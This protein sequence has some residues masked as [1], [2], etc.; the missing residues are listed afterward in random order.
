MGFIRLFQKNQELIKLNKKLNEQLEIVVAELNQ[1]KQE[2][3]EKEICK[4]T[5]ASRKRLTKHDLM[6]AEI[7]K[8]LVKETEEP[9]Y[10]YLILRLAICLLSVSR[11]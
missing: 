6:T 3:T 10:F 1:I 5:R 9:T 7:Y 8:E 4:Q 11:L 2:R